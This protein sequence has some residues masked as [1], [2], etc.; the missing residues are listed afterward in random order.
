VVLIVAS[1]EGEVRRG[2]NE[3]AALSSSW[4]QDHHKP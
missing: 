3:D 2:V 4:P 1:Q